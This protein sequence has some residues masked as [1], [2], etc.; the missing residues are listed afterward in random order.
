M[1][2]TIIPARGGSK[3]IPNKNLQKINGKTLIER[4]ILA[5]QKIPNNRIIVSSDSIEILRC[6]DK[7]NA[8][9]LVRS[10][11]NS[12]D[13]ATSEDVILEVLSLIRTQSDIITLLQPTS[14]F[15]DVK[16]WEKSL[17]NMS[18]DLEIDSMFSAIE[19][20]EF[21]WEYKKNWSPIGHDRS[22]R[23]PRQAQSQ[24]VIETGSFYIFR[25]TAFEKEKTRFCGL[26]KPVLTQI[27]SSFDI[28]SQSDL[29]FCN[30]ISHLIDSL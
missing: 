19:K 30:M 29:D 1:Y 22:I 16:A 17:T 8:Q 5:A 15:T 27:W 18:N 2:L 28:D 13:I 10:N 25:K 26:T 14:P 23:L 7:C 11:I 24:R 12:T 9:P 20:N 4:S 6:A 21:A 3:G